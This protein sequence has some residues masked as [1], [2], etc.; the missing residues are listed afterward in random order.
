MLSVSIVFTDNLDPKLVKKYLLIEFEEKIEEIKSD[1][2]CYG[3][4]AKCLKLVY[5]NMVDAQLKHP[6]E[7]FTPKEIREMMGYTERHLTRVFSCL[8]ETMMLECSSEDGYWIPLIHEKK[9]SDQLEVSESKR[10]FQVGQIMGYKNII[11]YKDL[12]IDLL[13]GIDP[14]LVD[15]ETK[16]LYK[17]GK[18]ELRPSKK[19]KRK[20]PEDLPVIDDIEDS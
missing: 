8:C 1:K 18:L 10:A 20:R 7:A 16:R 13:V 5:E 3:I 9:Q 14:N 17:E 11:E 6:L 19:V 2:C 15:E 12:E 4:S